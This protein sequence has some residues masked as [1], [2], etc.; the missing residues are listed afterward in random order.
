MNMGVLGLVQHNDKDALTVFLGE[1]AIAH[2]G[3]NQAIVDLY[4]I[5]PL[6]YPLDVDVDGF[7]G[8]TSSDWLLTHY[9]VHSN[10]SAQ[11]GLIGLPDLADVNL[12]NEQEF[13]DW[14]DAHNAEHDKIN[15][16]LGLL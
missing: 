8:A 3:I 7:L 15:Y 4:G 14:M 16:T 9:R 11:L 13:G 6:N 1:H 2:T 12:K 5:D 10:I